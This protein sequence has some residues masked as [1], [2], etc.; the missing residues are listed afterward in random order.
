MKIYMDLCALKRPFDDQTHA[1]VRIETTAVVSILDAAASGAFALC[2][3]AALVYENSLNPNEIR[4][5][6]AATLLGWAGEPAAPIDG[7]FTRA[8]DLAAQGFGDMDAL[9]LAFAEHLGADRFI[10][11]DD[12]I[13]ARSN[14]VKLAIPV[15]D[16][17]E[18][19]RG[20]RP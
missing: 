16:P 7:V 18:F 4:R 17:V 11:V 6:R 14:V 8:A 12:G 5:N 1:R 9:H 19:T 3:S 15:N 10:T 13:L 2:N 20:L